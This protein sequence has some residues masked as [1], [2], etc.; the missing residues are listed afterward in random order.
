MASVPLTPA[1]RGAVVGRRAHRVAWPAAPLAAIL[2]VA[3]GYI[4]L[5]YMDSHWQDWWAYGVFFLASAVF[6][7]AFA[8]AV[9]VWSNRWLLL[10][11]IAGNL[12]IVGMY[13]LSRLDGVPLGPH[14]GVKENAAVIDVG[15]TAAEIGV[16]VL[17]LVMVG[18]ATARWIFNALLAVGATLWVMRL[19]EGG[20]L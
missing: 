8:V 7:C 19:A 6:Q 9:L 20:L 18:G 3:A 1:R 11:G 16:V 2:S 14:A 13:V 5:A 4:H 12:G 15:T 10:A 17:L